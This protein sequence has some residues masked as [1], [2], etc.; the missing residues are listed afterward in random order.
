MVE[1]RYLTDG[2]PRFTEQYGFCYL[3]N[4]TRRSK[5]AIYVITE[6][7]AIHHICLQEQPRRT[8][9]IRS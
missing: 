9:W 8:P 4:R 5:Y 7:A 1:L 3:G 2:E 6:F